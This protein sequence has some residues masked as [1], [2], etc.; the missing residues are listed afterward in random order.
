MKKIDGSRRVLTGTVK[1]NTFKNSE[2]R[3]QLFDGRFD[4]GYRV[5][6]FRIIPKTPTDSEEIIATLS[7]EPKTALPTTY[8]FANNENVAYAAWNIPNQTAF[9][10]WNLVLEDNLAVED[11]WMAVYSTGD[12]DYCNY[13]LILEKYEFSDWTGALTMVRNR[14]QS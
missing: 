13:M 12:E 9:A 5:V 8:D 3:I 10:D 4:T 2:N 7:T 1:I 6:E 11:L 14:S